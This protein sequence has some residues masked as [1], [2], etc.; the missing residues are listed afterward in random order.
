MS[1]AL[2]NSLQDFIRARLV[3]LGW[4]H[5]DLGH[6][7]GSTGSAVSQ[8][9]K[10][11]AHFRAPDAMEYGAALT[12]DPAELLRIQAEYELSEE[13]PQ[14]RIRQRAVEMAQRHAERAREVQRACERVVANADDAGPAFTVVPIR[15]GGGMP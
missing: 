8:R 11:G 4:T 12:I 14:G 13:R 6:V 7:L 1:D 3:A 10:S 5:A 15:R 2:P 9:L